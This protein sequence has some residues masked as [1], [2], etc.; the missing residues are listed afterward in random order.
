MKKIIFIFLMFLLIV[1]L[2]NGQKIL[3]GGVS[4]SQE[5]YTVKRV[6]SGD[7]LELRNGEIVHLIGIN[8]PENKPI[9]YLGWKATDYNVKM[10]ENKQIRLEYD[11]QERDKSGRKLVYVYFIDEAR[12]SDPLIKNKE[13]FLNELL[14]ING[15]S[16][17]DTKSPNKKYNKIFI[18]AQNIAKNYKSGLWKLKEIIQKPKLLKKKKKI[19]NVH[20]KAPSKKYSESDINK[21][22][23][24]LA[25]LN[26]G[27]L[28]NKNDITITRF[29]YL[30]NS[31]DSKTQESKQQIADMTFKA[32][33]ILR[34][35]YGKEIG[36]LFLMENLNKSIP[37]GS[38]L[39]Y[40]EI[41]TAYI[42]LIGK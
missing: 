12:F 41:A 42:V 22:A 4:N 24:H 33:Q 11:I 40:A 26:K 31:L 20:K 28:V 3:K 19:N 6:V 5:F 39:S 16:K 18:N 37:E 21:I 17:V 2:S 32:Q 1:D 13:A 36:L 9:E 10:V 38:G 23:F 7:F 35:K 25:S 30:L 15:Y 14:I 34:E 27:S 29:K 8:I